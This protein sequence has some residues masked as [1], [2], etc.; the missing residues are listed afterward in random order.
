MLWIFACVHLWHC[1]KLLPL[2]VHFRLC[3]V[4]LPVLW[5]VICPVLP[6]SWVVKR[7][8]SHTALSKPGVIFNMVAWKRGTVRIVYPLKTLPHAG[9]SPEDDNFASLECCPTS[10]LVSFMSPRID[11]CP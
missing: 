2:A 7:V 8:L 3:P 11:Q 1:A 10:I 5:V 9:H 6:M 4:I